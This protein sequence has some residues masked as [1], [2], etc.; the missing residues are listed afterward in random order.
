MKCKCNK[1]MEGACWPEDYIVRCDKC[2]SYERDPK[3]KVEVR[4]VPEDRES[5]TGSF[6]M[7][8]VGEV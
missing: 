8:R 7:E 5:D 6:Q 2:E 3:R 4:E 1:K